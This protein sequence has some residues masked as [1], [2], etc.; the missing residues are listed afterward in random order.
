MEASGL[1]SEAFQGS[2][3]WL[4]TFTCQNLG[5]SVW[6]QESVI[7]VK[8]KCSFDHRTRISRVISLSAHRIFARRE[9]GLILFPLFDWA[10]VALAMTAR[11]GMDVTQ[12]LRMESGSGLG[13]TFKNIR[14]TLA[15]CSNLTT[16]QHL[17]CLLDHSPS[18]SYFSTTRVLERFL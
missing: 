8:T 12:R 5:K 4:G 15:H 9:A 17:L 10:S 14:E 1:V 18:S 2:V 7:R 16:P 3:L 6:S 13:Q 11:H